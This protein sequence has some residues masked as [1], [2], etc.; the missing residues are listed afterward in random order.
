MRKTEKTMTG[1][2]DTVHLTYHYGKASRRR[3]TET[4]GEAEGWSVL[5][6]K[7]LRSSR[8]AKEEVFVVLFKVAGAALPKEVHNVSDRSC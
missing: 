1:R 7:L 4:S 8:T 6:S 5:P 3:R 2:C